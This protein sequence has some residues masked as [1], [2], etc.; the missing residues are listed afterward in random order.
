MLTK[1]T[2]KNALKTGVLNLSG[3]GLG[4]VPDQVWNLEKCD[5]KPVGIVSIEFDKCPEEGD[6]WWNYKPLSNLDLSSNALKE[7]SSELS[8]LVDLKSLFVSKIEFHINVSLILL[9]DSANLQLQD[10]CIVSIPGEIKYLTKLTKINM[11]H[12]QLTCLPQEFFELPNLK[13]LNLSY[14]QFAEIDSR[15]SDL[16]MLEF[17]VSSFVLK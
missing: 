8:N 12:N 6:N 3:K 15:L 17:L 9:R 7:I 4:T 10:N 5:T 11:S 1:L 16:N 14:N 2:I 13:W